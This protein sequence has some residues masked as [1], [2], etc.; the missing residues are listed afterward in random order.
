MMEQRAMGGTDSFRESNHN[1]FITQ[2]TPGKS[3]T[4]LTVLTCDSKKYELA[5]GLGRVFHKFL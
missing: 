1:G 4:F 2:L 3:G 5:G